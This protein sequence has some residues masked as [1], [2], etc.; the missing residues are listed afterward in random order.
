MCVVSKHRPVGKVWKVEESDGDVQLRK[1][2]SPST[3]KIAHATSTRG[4]AD[5]PLPFATENFSRILT[6][7]GEFPIHDAWFRPDEQRLLKAPVEGS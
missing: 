7:A 3:R 2:S 1:V 5:C 4:G 6:V